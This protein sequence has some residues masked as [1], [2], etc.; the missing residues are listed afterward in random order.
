MGDDVE[1]EHMQD[2]L[3]EENFPDHVEEDVSGENIWLSKTLTLTLR[4]CP[5]PGQLP[6]PSPALTPLTHSIYFLP[7]T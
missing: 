6:S 1:E 4:H 7:T 5:T 3:G 2:D